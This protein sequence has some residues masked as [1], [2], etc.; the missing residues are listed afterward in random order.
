MAKSVVSALV[1][2]AISD[3][4]IKS[5]DQS[6][7]EFLPEI[8]DTRVDSVKLRDL[9][10]MTSGLDFKENM[11]NPFGKLPKLYYG[12]RMENFIPGI[13]YGYAPSTKFKYLNINTQL[14]AFILERATKMSLTDY[15][16]AKIWSKIGS[17]DKA[18]WVL[19]KKEGSERAYCCLNAS[20]LDFAKIGRLYMHN[21]VWEGERIIDKS[22]IEESTKLD[23]SRG[24]RWNNQY[25]WWK[26]KKGSSEFFAAGMYGQYIYINPDKNIIIV[27]FG[28]KWGKGI[29]WQRIFH[30]L[31]LVN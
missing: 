30:E 14:L 11:L 24:S 19:D 15:M 10:Q 20:S 26:I 3:G 12:R 1:G 25:C 18:I 6:I 27:R 21:G 13:K 22:W 29:Y 8:K 5:V 28:E 23:T 2:L 4:Y 7:R 9:L 16:N 31:S 17:S